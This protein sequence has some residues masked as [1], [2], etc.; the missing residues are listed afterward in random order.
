MW[1][2]K[3]RRRKEIYKESGNEHKKVKWLSK[4]CYCDQGIK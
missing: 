2:I 1:I 4:F 3:K